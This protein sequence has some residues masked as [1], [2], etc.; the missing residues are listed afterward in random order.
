[1]D[2]GCT[3]HMFPVKDYFETLELKEYG[4]VLLGNN[5]ACRVQGIGAVRLKMFDNQEMLLQN[6]RYVPKL[7]RKLMSISMFDVMG[8]STKVEG[9]ILKMSTGASIVAKGSK[10]N[11]LYILEGSTIIAHAS[12]AI[13]TILDKAKLWHL[14]LGHVSEKG[15]VELEKQ[16]LLIGD[17]LQKLDF[18]DLCVL[19][20]SHR[21]QFG[22]V[23]HTFSRPFEYA[24]ADLWGPSR[25]QTH[26]GGSYFL[27]IIDDF[28]RRVWIYI[29][30]KKAETFQKFKEWYTQIEN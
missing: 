9:G 6:V 19:G 14:R 17:K 29:L 24:H 20:K 5:K 16:Q 25:A 18:C 27:S 23:K 10:S 30:R 7:K 22:T 1:M 15:L 8:C 4:T 28:L 13:Q 3:Y 11:E 12:V 26:G 2:S 21:V